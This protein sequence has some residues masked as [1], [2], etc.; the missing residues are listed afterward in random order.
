MALW[1]LTLDGDLDCA[2][3]H[4]RH[5]SSR[6]LGDARHCQQII[7]PGEKLLLRTWRG[8]AVFGWRKFIDDSGQQGINCTVFRNESPHLSSSLIREAD[9]IAD[10]WWTDRRHYTY[11]DPQAVASANP[12]YCFLC[13]GWRRCGITP[14]GLIVLERTL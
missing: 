4:E 13:A 7:G 10:C 12:G 14:K 1:W 3:L 5:Y 6:K 11:V 8:D 2:E 9:Q